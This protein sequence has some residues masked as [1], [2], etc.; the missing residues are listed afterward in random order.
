MIIQLCLHSPLPGNET[1]EYP[2]LTSLPAGDS[3]ITAKSAVDFQ[4]QLP[5]SSNDY[6]LIYNPS[7]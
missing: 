5:P 1:H 4:L 2:T 7:L 6:K 3:S